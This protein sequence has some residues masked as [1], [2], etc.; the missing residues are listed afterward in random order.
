MKKVEDQAQCFT[1]KSNILF[2]GCQCMAQNKSPVIFLFDLHL[3]FFFL[4]QSF[5]FGESI[6][7]L[8]TYT[9][10]TNHY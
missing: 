8:H 7:Y 6:I 1:R 4:C 3:S 10:F 5:N 2:L 9:R